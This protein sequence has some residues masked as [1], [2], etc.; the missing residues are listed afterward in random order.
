[1]HLHLPPHAVLQPH[2]ISCWQF[3]AIGGS[4]VQTICHKESC[5]FHPQSDGLA[6]PSWRIVVLPHMQPAWY[7]ARLMCWTKAALVGGI[8]SYD[9]CFIF[10]SATLASGSVASWDFWQLG[11]FLQSL[12]AA[13]KDWFSWRKNSR[14]SH[15]LDW[16]DINNLEKRQQSSFKIFCLTSPEAGSGFCWKKSSLFLFWL[17]HKMSPHHL[18][19]HLSWML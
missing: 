1:M 10:G 7:A 8:T 16:Q 5:C 11:S 18:F 2:F 14:R 6:I 4:V 19:L 17:A 9:F 15:A 13:G 12:N 3:S